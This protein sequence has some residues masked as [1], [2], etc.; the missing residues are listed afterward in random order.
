MTPIHMALKHSAKIGTPCLWSIFLT[1]FE[2]ITASSLANDH[3][4]FEADKV[5]PIK[6]R[7]AAAVIKIIKTVVADSGSCSLGDDV[8]QRYAV[9]DQY[10]IFI[11]VKVQYLPPFELKGLSPCRLCSRALRHKRKMR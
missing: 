9:H 8:I 3:V 10:T 6:V 5:L 4:I 2:N 11:F 1:S 7:K